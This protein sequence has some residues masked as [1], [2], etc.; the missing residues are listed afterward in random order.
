MKNILL[1]DYL[2]DTI[3]LMKKQQSVTTCH[4][5]TTK[6]FRIDLITES[7]S[8]NRRSASQVIN[9][10]IVP[11]KVAKRYQG[12]FKDSQVFEIGEL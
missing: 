3:I 9:I 12:I 1:Y 10:G 4:G 6:Y 11:W 7:D 5:V 8:K 2:L